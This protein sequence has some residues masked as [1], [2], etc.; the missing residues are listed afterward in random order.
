VDDHR[1]RNTDHWHM[2]EIAIPAGAFFLL[3]IGFAFIWAIRE[4]A[5][6]QGRLRQ[7]HGHL[8]QKIVDSCREKHR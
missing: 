3:L 2:L 7:E 6:E 5:Q 1:R 4:T 8:M